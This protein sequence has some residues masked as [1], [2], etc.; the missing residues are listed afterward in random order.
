MLLLPQIT[1]D[2]DMLRSCDLALVGVYRVFTDKGSK[3][4]KGVISG[5]K[6]KN[7]QKITVFTNYIAECCH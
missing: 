2:G 4:I 1:C 6:A 5:L 7:I 3:V